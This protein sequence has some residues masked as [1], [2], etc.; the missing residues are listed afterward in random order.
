MRLFRR[1]ATLLLLLLPAA[2]PAAPPLPALGVQQEISVSG[3]SSG[4]YMAVQ[5][6][7]AHSMTVKGAGVLAGGPWGCAE[8]S[9]WRA[10]HNCMSPATW[11][12]V[13]SPQETLA[14]A[15]AAAQAGQIDPLTGLARD[16][17]WLFS[18]GQDHTV[19]RPVMDALAAFY[20]T[21]IAAPDLDYET[22]PEPGH[23]IPSQ[24]D[25]AA[26]PCPTTEPPY[27]NRCNGLDA[28]GELLAHLLGP[29]A[30]K[31]PVADGELL[32]FDQRPYAAAADASSMATTAYAYIPKDCRAGGCRLHVVFHGCRQSVDQ[33][34][35][36]FVQ[37]AG[38]N[39]WAE[40]N[41]LVVLYPQ[42]T[43]RYG[44]LTTWPPRWTYN[45]RACWDWWGYENGDYLS[46]Q[47]PQIRAVQAMVERLAAA[48]GNNPGA[49][50]ALGGR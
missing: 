34:G 48:P 43:P 6:H 40:A 1:L 39:R 50:P 26:N 15:T 49:T 12:P 30:P 7:L 33:I 28:P 2:S 31:A 16:K 22:P 35:E 42:T 44:W 18:G 23:A 41:R 5:F 13:P 10:L 20:R 29:L 21:W 38:Y 9:S 14:Q 17:V 4:A 36:R 45:P 37:G 27:I 46:R 25:P 3:L 8:G 11:A 47:A 19:A 24:D 32:A